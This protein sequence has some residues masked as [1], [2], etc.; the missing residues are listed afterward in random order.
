MGAGSGQTLRGGFDVILPLASG[1]DLLL[2][3]RTT[4][5]QVT[6]GCWSGRKHKVWRPSIRHEQRSASRDPLPSHASE[7]LALRTR[8]SVSKSSCQWT[9]GLLPTLRIATGRP[10]PERSDTAPHG[11]TAPTVWVTAV[12]GFSSFTFS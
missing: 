8:T 5:H 1:V 2:L 3:Y 9:P 4:S 6:L 10:R 11:Q 7:T 12:S